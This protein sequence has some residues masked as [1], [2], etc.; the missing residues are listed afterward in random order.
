MKL[1]FFFAVASMWHSV[2]A[3]EQSETQCVDTAGWVNSEGDGCDWYGAN[4]LQGCPYYGYSWDGGMGVADDNCCFCASTVSMIALVMLLLH[5]VSLR[6][7][8]Y[9]FILQAPNP[10]TS[11]P[12]T[13]SPTEPPTTACPTVT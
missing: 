11:S 8:I 5:V 13:Y 2:H 6:L 9:L 7:T 10:P 1:S 12:Y 4:D 3:Q